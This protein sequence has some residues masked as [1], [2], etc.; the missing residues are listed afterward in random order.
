[1]DAISFSRLF[2]PASWKGPAFWPRS[3][4]DE[5]FGCSHFPADSMVSRSFPTRPTQLVLCSI[6]RFLKIWAKC[7]PGVNVVRSTQIATLEKLSMA[8]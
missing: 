7:R 1:M 5:R 4:P 3:V 8:P 2:V 6:H